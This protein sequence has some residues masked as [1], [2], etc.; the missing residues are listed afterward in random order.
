MNKLYMILGLSVIIML[1]IRVYVRAERMGGFEGFAG[2]GGAEL[3]IATWK[4]CGHC[5]KAKPEFDRLS[6][7]ELPKLRD[8][9]AVTLRMLDA[10]SDKSE[11]ASLGIQGYPSILFLKDG[12]RIEYSGERTADGIISFLKGY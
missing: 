3:V 5:V 11:I 10:D 6:S 8:G 1:L 4:Q 12:Q 9:S 7:L 2:N